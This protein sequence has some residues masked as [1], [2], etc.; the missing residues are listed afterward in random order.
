MW[1][2]VVSWSGCPHSLWRLLEVLQHQRPQCHFTGCVHLH[3]I[4]VDVLFA[5]QQVSRHFW[6][7]VSSYSECQLWISGAPTQGSSLLCPTRPQDRTMSL[8]CRPVNPVSG[9]QCQGSIRTWHTTHIRLCGRGFISNCD[10]HS[11]PRAARVALVFCSP[12]T[13]A[14]WVCVWLWYSHFPHAKAHATWLENKRERERGHLN[15]RVLQIRVRSGVRQCC[16]EQ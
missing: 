12:R 16:S 4:W 3:M 15:A 10:P 6:S 5:L 11:K 1:W 2:R 14:A 8:G 7:D 13:R 9:R